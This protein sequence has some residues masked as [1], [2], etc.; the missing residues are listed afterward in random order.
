LPLLGR[1]LLF[2]LMPKAEPTRYVNLGVYT[3]PEAARFTRVSRFRI[4]RWLRGYRVSKRNKNYRPL[5]HGQFPPLDGKLALG[6]LDLVEIKF[7][8]CFL[9][10]GV[11]WDMI[12][13]ARDKA[14][15]LFPGETHPFCTRRFMTNGQQIF[16]QLHDETGAQ[17]LLDLATSQQLF[18][19]IV[20]PLLTELEFGDGDIL[21]RWWPCGRK[22]G[23]ALDP[24]RSFGQPML[25]KEGIP[26]RVLARS[27][28]A[29]TIE[30]VARWYEIDVQSVRDAL[31]FEEQF[32]A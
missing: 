30:E 2:T 23:V 16:V 11:T 12:H 25:F 24:R 22:C 21:E 8:D 14:A 1:S 31:Q 10:Q 9:Q 13:K 15:Q 17:S 4:R 18:S 29:N 7:V 20:A 6:F 3:I 28:G 32:A 26:T 19:G 27:A 5:W